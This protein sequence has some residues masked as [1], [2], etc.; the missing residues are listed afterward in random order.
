MI[1]RR[2][3]PL[4]IAVALASSPMSWAPRASAEPTAADLSAARKKFDRAVELEKAGDFKAA[5]ALLRDV[6]AI[7]PT[8]QVRF[9]VAL[10]LERLGRLVEAREE[11]LRVKEEAETKEGPEGTALAQKAGDR[12]TDLD[13]RIPKVTFRLPE[14]VISAKVSI[15][16]GAPVSVLVSPTIRLDPGEHKLLVTS[17]GRRSFS[18]TVMVKERDAT[19]TLDVALPHAEEA[20]PEQPPAPT[21]APV[22]AGPKR[23][24]DEAPKSSALPWIIGGVGVASLATAGVFY[25]LRDSAIHDLDAACGAGRESCPRAMKSTEDQ[26]RLYT[27]TANVFAGVGA[28]AIGTAI[29][30]WITQPSSKPHAT[31]AVAASPS[32]AGFTFVAPF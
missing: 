20:P 7:K 26:G 29:V 2:S 3:I 27:T 32:H 21:E 13:A 30:V 1:A 24:V 11:Y 9:H 8:S 4:L 15:D 23:V 5:L 10:C 22:S 31:V 19:F 28:A 16:D 25:A 18:R 6:A 12:V 17:P 14:D